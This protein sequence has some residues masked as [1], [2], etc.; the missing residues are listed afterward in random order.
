MTQR[1]VGGAYAVHGGKLLQQ[2]LPLP[3]HRQVAR[4]TGLCPQRCLH[5]QVVHLQVSR[6]LTRKQSCAH[7]I[8]FTSASAV[9]FCRPEACALSAASMASLYTCAAALLHGTWLTSWRHARALGSG[10]PQLSFTNIAAFSGET[11]FPPASSEQ[12]SRQKGATCTA[13]QLAQ[14]P[15][16]GVTHACVSD[17]QT[18]Q[19]V[20]T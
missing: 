13:G 10:A 15:W 9:G 17:C 6:L 14:Q 19:M 2:P 1:G 16:Q 11:A 8:C 7:C 3:L 20:L 5:G 18:Q 4:A 12:A